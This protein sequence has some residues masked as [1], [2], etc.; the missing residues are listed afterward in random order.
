MKVYGYHRTST[1]E[2][3]LDRGIKEIEDF[4]ISNNIQLERIYTD[5]QTGKSF[6]R[7]RYIVLKNDILRSGDI[8]IITELDRL[9]RN[10]RETLKQLEFFRD[11]DIR[12][13]ILEIPTTLQSL[14]NM[15]NSMSKMLMDTI[16]SMLIELFTTMAQAEIE[17]KEKR[18]KEGI[19]A[20]K[21][22]GDWDDYGRPR[23]TKPSNWDEVIE[24][25]K[26]G[27]ITSVE[28]MRIMNLK[29]GTYY[30]FRKECP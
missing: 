14:T 8:L 11:K 9:G 6:D 25:V 28:A 22:R 15:E 1:R 12:V 7:P 13:M 30:K 19:E 18:Q 20:K 17:K 27:E 3:H 24:K 23:I 10:K 26:A 5:Q 16:N 2:Q 4:C 29:K 21:I